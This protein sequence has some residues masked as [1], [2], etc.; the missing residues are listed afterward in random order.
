MMAIKKRSKV[1]NW[2][3]DFLF[4]RRD[5][6][7]GDLPAW[8]KEKP[9][10]NPFGPFDKE[11]RTTRYFLC[12]IGEDDRPRPIPEFMADVIVRCRGPRKERA[13]LEIGSLGICF[14]R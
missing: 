8:D 5:S 4:V 10:R 3:Y 7:W 12:Y 14:L 6:G 2:K 9:I 13:N 1:K 11:R